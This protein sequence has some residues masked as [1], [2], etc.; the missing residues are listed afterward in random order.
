MN[1]SAVFI[2]LYRVL[3]VCTR[4]VYTSGH[5]AR[6]TVDVISDLTSVIIN[7][8]ETTGMMR[9]HPWSWKHQGI[10]RKC[11]GTVHVLWC[12]S[13]YILFFIVFE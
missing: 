13:S 10:G 8:T 11:M 3:I 4:V 6:Q 12:C 5:E 7:E 9:I 2:R 1:S